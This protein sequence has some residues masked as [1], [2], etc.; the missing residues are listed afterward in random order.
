MNHGDKN[1]KKKKPKEKGKKNFYPT[2]RDLRAVRWI[3][4][5]GIAQVEDVWLAIYKGSESKSSRYAE[6]RLR[7]LCRLGYLKRIRVFGSGT[8]NYVPTLRGLNHLSELKSSDDPQ[9]KVPL[10]SLP[11]AVKVASYAHR[12]GL[13]KCRAYIQSDPRVT[14]WV[15]DRSLPAHAEAYFQ[16][17]MKKFLK[18]ARPDAY[19]LFSGVRWFLEYEITQKNKKMYSA[20]KDRYSSMWHYYGIRGVVFVVLTESL[21]KIIERNYENTRFAFAIFT[22]QELR[23][24]KVQE[25]LERVHLSDERKTQ[26]ERNSILAELAKYE[27]GL[28]SNSEELKRKREELRSWKEELD[29]ANEELVAY[30]K[31]LIKFDAT[32][33]RLK[34]ELEKLE[35]EVIKLE[36]QEKTLIEAESRYKL[37]IESTTKS[38]KELS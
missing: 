23:E 6:E 17:E 28:A 24:G 27:E 34:S 38:L 33:A 16:D 35:Q 3:C 11:R 19:F 2:Q 37:Y 5:Q 21:R 4:E 20:K 9:R 18:T 32:E 22:E 36:W 31:R 1:Q 26:E 25:Y 7:G 30:R 15:N 8:T 29:Q 12:V 13:N 10:P 14:V